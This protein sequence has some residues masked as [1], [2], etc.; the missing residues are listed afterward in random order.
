MTKNDNKKE[1]NAN[2]NLSKRFPFRGRRRNFGKQP[3]FSSILGG[4]V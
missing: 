3:Q 1:N 4:L 2:Q